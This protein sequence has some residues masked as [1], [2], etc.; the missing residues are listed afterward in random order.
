MQKWFAALNIL[1]REV[2]KKEYI[3]CRKI[4]VTIVVIR[5]YASCLLIIGVCVNFP[6][7]IRI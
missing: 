1:K 6:S 4:S 5:V 3:F 2:F 7:D